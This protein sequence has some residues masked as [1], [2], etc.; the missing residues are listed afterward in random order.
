MFAPRPLLERVWAILRRSLDPVQPL[1]AF[2]HGIKAFCFGPG[3]VRSRARRVAQVGGC[4]AVLGC[5]SLRLFA[6]TPP[7]PNYFMRVWQTEE[8]LP[9]NAVTA[10]VQ[11]Q[12]GYLWLG[13]YDG[14]ARF[15]GA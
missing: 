4:A 5:A 11:T 9:E 6:A 13:T 12:E 10:V 3:R 8:G 2:C 1:L 7:L 15:D 14:L